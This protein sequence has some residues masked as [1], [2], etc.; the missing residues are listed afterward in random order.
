MYLIIAFNYHVLSL[1]HVDEIY[2]HA[3]FLSPANNH[4]RLRQTDVSCTR[5]SCMRLMHMSHLPQVFRNSNRVLSF[6]HAAL[7]LASSSL[8]GNNEWQESESAT[9]TKDLA[10]F[11]I[12]LS[13]CISVN[14]VCND[15]SYIASDMD[16]CQRF[17]GNYL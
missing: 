14:T 3:S 13:T 1:T 15:I 6:R 4:M 2:G 12:V 10:A 17:I 9:C 8:L 11:V 5:F 16:A 7:K